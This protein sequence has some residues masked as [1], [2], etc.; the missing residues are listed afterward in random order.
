MRTRTRHPIQRA[1]SRAGL[2]LRL[3][4]DCRDVNSR[5]AS[6]GEIFAMDIAQ[7]GRREEY[8]MAPGAADVHAVNVDARRHQIVL[9]VREDGGRL[10]VLDRRWRRNLYRWETRWERVEIDVPSS[11]RHL[12]IGLDERHLFACTL[13]RPAV[14]VADTHH[15]LAPASVR[16]AS[17]GVRRQGEWFLRPIDSAPALRLLR[18]IE[19]SHRLH[20]ER[21]CPLGAGHRRPARRR[22]AGD[23]RPHVADEVLPLLFGVEELRAELSRAAPSVSVHE[24]ARGRVRHP[25]HRTL[26][27]GAHWHVVERNTEPVAPAPVAGMTWID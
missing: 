7:R 24:L 2:P 21:N 1:F 20:I 8:V 3:V 17:S 22:F 23:R 4:D 12:L 19:I 5:M 18:N 26:D 16:G 13:P 11:R 14:T 25:D 9:H 6:S 10:T 27:L 15:L